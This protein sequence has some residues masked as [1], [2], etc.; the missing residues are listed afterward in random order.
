[1]SR[2]RPKGV[3]AILLKNDVL[4]EG[5]VDDLIIFTETFTK[6]FRGLSKTDGQR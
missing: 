4:C 2:N 1:M 3:K 5:V 6:Y